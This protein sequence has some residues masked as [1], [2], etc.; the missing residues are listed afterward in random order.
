MTVDAAG[1][2]QQARSID[3]PRRRA[4]ILAQ[5]HDASVTN[6]DMQREISAAVT[7]VPPRMARSRVIAVSASL[8]GAIEAANQSV[9][10][11]QGIVVH[12]GHAH[13]AAVLSKSKML[14]QPPRME[15]AKPDAQCVLVGFGHHRA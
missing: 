8:Q 10:L 12:H 9:H 14:D 1:Q 13:D 6:A 3:G 5:R 7:T 15:V 2:H 4:D 11:G